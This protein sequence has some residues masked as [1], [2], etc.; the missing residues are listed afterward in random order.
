MTSQNP[1]PTVLWVGSRLMA[2]SHWY[3]GDF[4]RAVAEAEA[5]VGLAPYDANTLSRMSRIQI[6]AGNLS[7]GIEWATESMQRDPTI[8]RNTRILAWA[9]YLAGD[10]EKSVEAAREHEQLSRV[11]AQ[12]AY[13]YMAASYVRLGRLDE[14]RAAVA[15][16]LKM[17]PQWSQLGAREFYF[18]QPYKNR[19]IED[20]ELSD[21]AT[22]GMPELSFGYDGASKD[23]LSSDDIKV[24]LFGH[25]L[26]GYNITINEGFTHVIAADGSISETAQSG[27][28]ATATLTYLQNGV[29]CHSWVEWGPVCGAIL[30]NPGGAAEQHDEYIWITAWTESRFSVEK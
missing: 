4:V 24:L 16:L 29:I 19:G 23:R 25:T 30:R 10:Y 27:K 14:A 21:L 15:K 9:Y 6:A 20:A 12:D 17:E 5:A 8:P 18:Q 11:F 1:L 13:W 22:A 7:R 2:Y 3:E 26:R 28:K